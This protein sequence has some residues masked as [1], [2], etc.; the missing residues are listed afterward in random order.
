M[1]PGRV[2]TFAD[3]AAYFEART[4]KAKDEDRRAELAATARFYR[5]LAAIT[6]YFP[7][8][9]QQQSLKPADTS[10]LSK[11]A[12]ECR[13]IA[14]KMRDPEC[15]AKLLRLAETYEKVFGA[16]AAE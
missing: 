16:V 14:A 15:K 3:T 9:Y 8:G 7:F 11:R 12:E 6:L 2:P 1:P 5:E 13:A 10:R 4:K